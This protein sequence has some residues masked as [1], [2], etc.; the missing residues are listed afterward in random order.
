[1]A[2]PLLT[3]YLAAA[4]LA[5]CTADLRPPTLRSGV[6]AD[7]AA[8][9]R[10]LL[11]KMLAAHG[12]AARF[13]AAR[14]ARFTL[15][16]TWPQWL[17]RTAAMPWPA[18]GQRLRAEFLLGQDDGRLTFLGGDED[19]WVWGVQDWATW[20]QRPGQAR[21]WDDDD[22]VRF[23]VPTLAYFLELPFRIGE[24]TVV[25]HGGEVEVAGQTYTTVF[26][27]WGTAEPQA[28]VDQYVLYLDPQTHRLAYAAY[29]VR[30]MYGFLK[31]AVRY[32]DWQ[33]VGGLLFPQRMTMTDVPGGDDVTHEVRIEAA[34]VE[35]K[36]P[37]AFY[38]PEPARAQAKHGADT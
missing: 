33:P 31:G 1:M 17:N 3:L 8:Q 16:D 36:Q 19:G 15:T 30:D 2:R 22:D 4:A 29:T 27:S 37:D 18:S 5:G 28:D 25:A 9:G 10:A 23:W 12:G 11:A 14:D 32:Q 21:D 26:A 20:T 24:A 6:A 34:D 35:L 38:R 7:Q 13:R